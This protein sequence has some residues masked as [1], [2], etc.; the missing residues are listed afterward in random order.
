[1]EK[2]N[3]FTFPV[4]T[5]Q[6]EDPVIAGKTLTW[7]EPTCIHWKLRLAKVTLEVVIMTVSGAVSDDKVDIMTTFGF[8]CEILEILIKLDRL[9]WWQV[10][11]WAITLTPYMMLPLFATRFADY[12]GGI[13]VSFI[14]PRLFWF[15]IKCSVW[16][17]YHTDLY[18]WNL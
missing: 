6:N 8:H 10:F 17:I 9:S 2:D 14:Q 12:A 15:N 7:L 16:K 4:S 13:W 5:L 18:G 11:H 1:M 3:C